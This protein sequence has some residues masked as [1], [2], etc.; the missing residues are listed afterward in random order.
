M[1]GEAE[2]CLVWG[3]GGYI[4][5]AMDLGGWLNEADSRPGIGLLR[6]FPVLSSV[7]KVGYRF[8][9]LAEMSVIRQF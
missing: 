3:L 1:I 4:K 9:T 8:P 2:I 7:V 6:G 5:D